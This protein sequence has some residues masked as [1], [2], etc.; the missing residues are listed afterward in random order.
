MKIL[1]SLAAV[2]FCTLKIVSNTVHTWLGL[3][4]TLIRLEMR[5]RIRIHDTETKNI[6]IKNILARLWAISPANKSFLEMR[7][8]II[9][10]QGH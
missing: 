1:K 6:K 9:P 3:V 5:I 7:I 8:R 2:L 4:M 10:D